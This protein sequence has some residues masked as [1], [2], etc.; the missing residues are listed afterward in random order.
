MAYEE[1]K[2]YFDGSHYI[3]I[4]HSTRPT[5]PRLKAIEEIITV[6]EQEEVNEISDQEK[7]EDENNNAAPKEAAVK[8]Q[9]ARKR[10]IT[11]KELFEELYIK[12]QYAKRNERRRLIL[13]AMRPYFKSEQEAE[14]YVNENLERK[15]R[16]LI[17][18]RSRM[19]RKANLQDFNYFVTFTYDSKLHTEQSF[20]KGLRNCLSHLCSRKEWKYIGV[21][22]RSPKKDRLHFH[23]IFHIPDGTMPGML[24]AF[25]DYNFNTHKRQTIW[26]NT[27]FLEKFGRCDFERFDNIH[28]KGEALA[29]IM[30][31]IDKS[32]EKIVYSRGLAQY[33]I[34]DILE[35]DVVCTVGMEDQ[36]L[37]LYDDFLCFDNGVLVGPVS[38]DT[39]NQLRKSN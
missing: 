31:Y 28:R 25:N 10:K 38:L 8:V 39:I 6:T 4:P 13:E 19:C 22:E 9:A 26:Q 21:W 11:R 17:C 35:D 33:F 29:Y 1:A 34:S 2:V 5:K 15:Q 30:K 7:Q 23:G 20:R 16:N 27:Y 24:L 37:L 14:K 18:R 36:K 3:A 32:G 12:Y